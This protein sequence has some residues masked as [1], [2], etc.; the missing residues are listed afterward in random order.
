MAYKREMTCIVCPLG[1]RISV[2]TG[3]DG[4]ITEISGNKCKRGASY[5]EEECLD[6]KRT[7]TTT[8]RMKNGRMPVVPVKTSK[9]VPK[10]LIMDCMKEINRICAVP[11]VRIGDVLIRDILGTGADVVAAGNAD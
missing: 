2:V 3:D 5:A 10:A 4:L 9:P 11:P 8:V 7:V 6:P 1:C